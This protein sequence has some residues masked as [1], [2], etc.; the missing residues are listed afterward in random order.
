MSW[1]DKIAKKL[2]GHTDDIVAGVVIWSLGGY[3]PR[4][5]KTFAQ[6]AGVLV[7]EATKEAV[8]DRVARK[9]KVPGLTP[10][11]KVIID[12]ALDVLADSIK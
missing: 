6:L 10:D 9:L 4:T 5:I 12:Y 11:Q 8:Y 1:L 3:G 7:G 2:R